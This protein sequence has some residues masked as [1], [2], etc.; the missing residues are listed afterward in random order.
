MRKLVMMACA[1]TL[2]LGT[3]NAGAFAQGALT[4]KEARNYDRG[5]KGDKKT[6]RETTQNREQYERKVNKEQARI[7][8]QN[9]RQRKKMDRQ[10]R[11]ENKRGYDANKLGNV[12]E[13]L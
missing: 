4:V 3:L 2:L 1:G 8:R 6:I 10:S 11:K 13:G 9:A 5:D 7:D 12:F